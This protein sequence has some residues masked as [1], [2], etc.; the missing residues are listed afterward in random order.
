MGIVANVFDFGGQGAAPRLLHM[1]DDVAKRCGRC[2]GDVAWIDDGVE[3]GFA[4]ANSLW[5]QAN[6]ITLREL[7]WVEVGREATDV[8]V[9]VNERIDATLQRAIGR[10][11]WCCWLAWWVIVALS[12]RF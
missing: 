4:K 10:C 6:I 1:R 9:S 12:R 11:A 7:Q 2:N 5:Q 8:A 3:I